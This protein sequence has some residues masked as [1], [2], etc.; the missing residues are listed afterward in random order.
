LFEGLFFWWTTLGVVSVQLK[1]RV[2]RIWSLL[3]PVSMFFFAD[4][5]LRLGQ[6]IDR[7]ELDRANLKSVMDFLYDH[8]VVGIQDLDEGQGAYFVTERGLSVLRVVGPLV[9]EA[10]R[11]QTRNYEAI[12]DALSAV[13]LNAKKEE[14]VVEKKLADLDDCTIVS[15][16][17]RSEKDFGIYLR[18]LFDK[19]RLK[20]KYR[21][22]DAWY[23]G[24]LKKKM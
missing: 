1:K 24:N 4:G 9:K 16:H 3:L 7:V 8:C 23:A 22:P 20:L 2:L 18:A 15:Q 13:N 10:Q 6:L 17:R 19:D 5:S 12:S 14:R 11:I 21:N